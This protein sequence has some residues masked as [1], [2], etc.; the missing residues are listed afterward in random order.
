MN[1]SLR[2]ALVRAL[3]VLAAGIFF[4]ARPEAPRW[5]TI[6][7]GVAFILPGAVALAGTFDR[8]RTPRPSA[9][10]ACVGT[11]CLLFGAALAAFPDVFRPSLMYVLAAALAVAAALEAVAMLALRRGGSRLHAA[12]LAVPALLLA[13]AVLLCIYADRLGPL[14]PFT[15]LGAGAI[16]Y[17]LMELGLVATALRS[18]RRARTASAGTAP[19]PDS[20]GRLPADSE[21]SRD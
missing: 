19:G 3:C 18:R 7:A 8:R 16:L 17:G 5:F 9:L 4:V 12:F 21:K 11:G 2:N 15:L 20:P 10:T 13:G 14:P 6:A 1:A